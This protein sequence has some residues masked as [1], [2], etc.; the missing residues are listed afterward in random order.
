MI[1]AIEITIYFAVAMGLIGIVTL[2]V[3]RKK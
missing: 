2:I 1:A 3:E